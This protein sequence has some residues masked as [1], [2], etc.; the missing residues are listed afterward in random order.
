MSNQPGTQQ[1][2]MV[3]TLPQPRH[4]FGWPPGSIRA[5]LVLIVVALTCSLML[6]TR[7]QDGAI[8]AIP[9]YL[10]YLLFMA[11][12]Y[13][14][15]V[16]GH[17]KEVHRDVSPPLWLPTGSIRLIIM[18]AVVATITWKV[19]N[20]REGL[21]EQL[22][23]SAMQIHAQPLLPVIILGGFFAGVLFRLLVIGKHERS[24]WALDLEAWVALIGIM[25]MGIS[26]IIHLIINPTLGSDLHLA[27]YEGFLSG[28]VT[29]YFGLRA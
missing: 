24:P 9:P 6:I 1:V 2:M 26:A 11:V 3:P 12:G 27:D 28:V 22:R 14:F 17:G 5:I 4:A 16:R 25:L 29:F 19:V 10:F 20:D 23:A 18:A 15:A 13:Y 8:I 7:R 21:L